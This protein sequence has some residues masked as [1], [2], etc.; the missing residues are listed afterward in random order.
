MWRCENCE[1]LNEGNNCS[2]C[3]YT[4]Q[5]KGYNYDFHSAASGNEEK[6]L[7]AAKIILISAVVVAAVAVVVIMVKAMSGV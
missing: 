4:Q 2:V 7:S 5:P 3:G 6:K 1:T